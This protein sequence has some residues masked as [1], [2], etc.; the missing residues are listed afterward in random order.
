MFE[1]LAKAMAGRK[2]KVVMA[3]SEA[4]TNGKTITLPAISDEFIGRDEVLNRV[5]HGYTDHEVGHCKY[6]DFKAF[7]G[8]SS[9]TFKLVN[10]LEDIRIERKMIAEYPGA[11]QNIQLIAFMDI[12]LTRQTL[13]IGYL[14]RA[15]KPTKS[16]LLIVIKQKLKICLVKT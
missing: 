13:C 11:R 15:R 7:F 5:L 9:A 3:G 4:M 12:N 16:K 2:I 10:T 1:K 14:L 8:L 6:S